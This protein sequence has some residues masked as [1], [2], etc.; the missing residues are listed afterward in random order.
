VQASAQ[1]RDKL[2]SALALDL[3][4]PAPDDAAHAE[5]VL[6]TAPSVW[7][8]TGFLV[9]FEAPLGEREGDDADG[10]LDAIYKARAGD[11]EAAPEA[12]AARKGLFPSSIGLSLLL[13]ATAPEEEEEEAYEPP[14]RQCC[15][16]CSTGQ[17]CGDSCISASKTCRKGRG[18]A[19]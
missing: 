1:V 13:P 4:G 8:L 10:E 14:T 6:P 11:D 15:K 17:P 9:P 18:C 7:Y 5:E 19:C 12:T 3:V 2:A 16:Y